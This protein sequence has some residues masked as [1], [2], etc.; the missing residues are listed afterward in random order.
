MRLRY[1]VS[2]RSDS[3]LLFISP[4]ERSDFTPQMKALCTGL[5]RRSVTQTPIRC[6]SHSAPIAI[7]YSVAGA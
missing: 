4:P 3:G 1:N 5:V 2:L 6:E 7:L